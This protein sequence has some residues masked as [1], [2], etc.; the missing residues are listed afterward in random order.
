M[1]GY[2]LSATGQQQE[3]DHKEHIIRKLYSSDNNYSNKKKD[4]AEK[5][6]TF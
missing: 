2:T 6:L 4:K 3:K 5:K 1:V